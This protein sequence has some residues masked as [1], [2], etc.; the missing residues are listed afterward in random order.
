[1]PGGGLPALGDISKAPAEA[2]LSP[3]TQVT[4]HSHR[5]LEHAETRQAL[6]AFGRLHRTRKQ[7][8]D[9]QSEAQESRWKRLAS[10]FLLLQ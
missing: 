7:E 9:V 4:R 8:H 3:R 1:M 6:A 5:S 10:R 2:F